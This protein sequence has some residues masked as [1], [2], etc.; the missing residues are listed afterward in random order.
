MTGGSTDREVGPHLLVQFRVI[1]CPPVRTGLLSNLS[2]SSVVELAAGGLWG[3]TR[4]HAIM[5]CLFQIPRRRSLI[6]RK[7]FTMNYVRRGSAPKGQIKCFRCRAVTRSRDGAWHDL[8]NRQVF[9][10]LSCGNAA[11]PA[12]SLP[13]A[14]PKLA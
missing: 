5:I 2:Y 14:A 10:C 13:V 8:E 1:S 11:R 3:L 9:L 7:G 4:I 6:G 12:I